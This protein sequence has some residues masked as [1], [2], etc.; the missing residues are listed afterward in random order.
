MPNSGIKS[1]YDVFIS[2]RWGRDSDFAQALFDSFSN[3]VVGEDSRAVQVFLDKVRLQGGR[4]FQFDFAS[5]LAS[6]LVVA[7]LLSVDAMRKMLDHDPTSEDNVLVE[8]MLALECY[9]SSQSR[10]ARIFP[11]GF[12]TR[13]EHNP[14]VVGDL[15]AEGLIDK[16]PDTIPE[17]SAELV[18]TLMLQAGMECSAELE[19]QTVRD[20]V[21]KLSK[22]LM[23]PAWTAKKGRVVV[24]ASK[25]VVQLLRGCEGLE[26]EAQERQEQ[27]RAAAAIPTTPTASAPAS[28]SASAS[29]SASTPA[30]APL[31]N[32]PLSSL[33]T[34]EVLALMQREGLVRLL[35]PF[36]ENN[37][38][39][40][41]LSY[42][43][44]LADVMDP[45]VGVVG[46]AMAK[47][48]LAKIA[49]WNVSGV[50]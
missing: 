29:K 25:H 20:V 48:L 32:R 23:F 40:L 7:P 16:L 44:E 14:N 37:I 35:Q 3:H 27:E 10:V 9:A 8:W 6:S 41:V 21:R 18:R 19:G 12:G 15:F 1:R 33:T 2:Y 5:A 34:E 49:E 36:T 50:P 42:C 4:Q 17:A 38:T 46:K 47:A 26:E 11:I 24:E 39:G 43:E 45:E 31:G 22:F 13:A 30:S 28:A